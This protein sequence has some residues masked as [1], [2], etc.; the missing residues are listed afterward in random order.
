M[1]KTIEAIIT[2]PNLIREQWLSPELAVREVL[3]FERRFGAK[4]LMLACH[5]ALPLILTPTLLNLI[6]INFL[7]EKQIPWVAEVDFLLSPLCRPIDEGLFEVEPSVR[8]VLLVELENQFS[9]E[10]PFELAKFLQFYLDHQSMSPPEITR[11]Q[12]WIAQAYTDPDKVIEELTTLR[13]ES[14][15]QS[16]R[17]LG[18]PEHIHLAIALEILAEPLEA[19]NRQQEY[20][21]LLRDSRVLAQL[22][23]GDEEEL[24]GSLSQKEAALLSPV[25]VKWV[26]KETGVP[27]LQTFE[28]DV[29]TVE[30]KRSGFFGRS[31]KLNI[32]R[33]R[34]Q[35]QHFIENLP[36]NVTLEMVAIPGGTF[37][38]GAPETE[39]GSSNSERPQHEV[40]V[41]PFFMGKYPVTQAQWRVVANLPQVNRQLHPDPS[42]FKGEN[43]PVEC[44]SWYD[45]VEFCDRLSVHTKRH[46]RLPS[47]AEWEYSCRAGTT[48]PFHFGKTITPELANYN[49]E[50]T[51][52]SGSKGE[53]REKTTPVGIFNAN[54]FGLYDMHGNVWEWCND[55]RYIDYDGFY[56]FAPRGGSWNS[57][58]GDCRSAAVR[59][60][61]MAGMISGI[62][63]RVVVSVARI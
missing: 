29:A 26:S 11:T 35:A 46:Y 18:T 30:V 37:I 6:Q 32:T 52:G 51:Y 31:S 7:E 47:E 15:S 20:Q 13:D 58:P 12:R 22:L 60:P 40:T 59:S 28:F 61:V 24:Q 57:N 1:S 14:L 39:E 45:A 23:Y 25:L 44:V 3:A 38:M 8:E 53:Y 10:R 33:T 56:S 63:F 19:T 41:P 43:L 21:V 2:A 16:D 17:P 54:A 55:Y 4:H 36:N 5:A 42:E 50:Y 49:G 27:P 34:H 9:W 48:T 62:G